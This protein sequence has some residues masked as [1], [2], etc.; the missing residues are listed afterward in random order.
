MS[1]LPRHAAAL[2]APIAFAGACQ[3]QAAE[4]PTGPPPAIQ[5]TA[6]ELSAAHTGLTDA[7]SRLVPSLL[8]LERFAT[9]S[10]LATQLEAVADALDRSDATALTKSVARAERL[11]AR[12]EAK[13]DGRGAS[14]I[15]AIRIA[16]GEAKR[17]IAD[18]EGAAGETRTSD[19][20]E[21]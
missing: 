19:R 18:G 7:T 2:L 12:L 11:L 3:D 21:P 14:D 17:L 5:A 10:E 6:A 8:A 4:S 9:E 1:P 20:S 16:L 15:D 13:D